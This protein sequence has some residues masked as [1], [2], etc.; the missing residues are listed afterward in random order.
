MTLHDE[1]LDNVAL[2]ALGVLPASETAQVVA[3]L[4]T[5]EQCRAEYELLRPAVTAVGSSAQVGDDVGPSPMLKKRI[6][7][8]VRASASAVRPPVRWQTWAAIAASFIVVIGALAYN[9]ALN[10]R[11]TRDTAA[12]M[13][14]QSAALADIAS[15]DTQR[16]HFGDGEVFVRGSRLYVALPHLETPPPGKVYQA[17]TLP[18]GSKKMAPSVTFKP[19]EEERDVTIVRLPESAQGVSAVAVSVEPEGGS[20]QP[21]SKPIAVTAL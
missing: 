9:V 8:E 20:K 2:Y 5:C 7:R 10:G 3:H 1:M 17:W 12:R 18:K 21:T 13:A 15:A 11:V 4:Q 19:D 14:A 6:M 16:F